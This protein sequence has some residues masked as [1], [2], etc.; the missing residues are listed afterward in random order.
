[1][2]RQQRDKRRSDPNKKKNKCNICGYPDIVKY[3]DKDEDGRL[4]TK[5][6]EVQCLGHGGVHGSMWNKHPD[7]TDYQKF[8]TR[9]QHQSREGQIK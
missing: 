7:Y 2:A 9:Q 6:H 1:M 3:E 4:V 5:E 8:I